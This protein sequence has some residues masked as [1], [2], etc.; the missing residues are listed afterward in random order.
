MF[1]PAVHPDW[2]HADISAHTQVDEH[3]KVVKLNDQVFPPPADR[4]HCLSLEG[5]VKLPNCWDHEAA[6][7]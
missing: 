4:N 2:L 3:P 5:A 7:P 1:F 6:L